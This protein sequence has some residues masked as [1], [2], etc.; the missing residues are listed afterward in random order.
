[1]GTEENAG[2]VTGALAMV[3]ACARAI[4]AAVTPLPGFAIVLVV[5]PV[6]GGGCEGSTPAVA[7]LPRAEPGP[8]AE[9]LEGIVDLLKR[10]PTPHA[11]T[12]PTPCGD[13]GPFEEGCQRP[14]GHEGDHTNWHATSGGSGSWRNVPRGC[15]CGCGKREGDCLYAGV[16]A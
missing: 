13:P 3:T 8:L 15:A 16:K 1:M 2:D 6:G 11:V 7:S 14:K 12:V 10:G 5:L 4:T 9:A